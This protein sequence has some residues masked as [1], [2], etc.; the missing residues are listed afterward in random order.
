MDSAGAVR[1][2]AND[3]R[4]ATAHNRHNAHAPTCLLRIETFR[5]RL[6]ANFR[7]TSAVNNRWVRTDR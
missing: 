4:H 6:R 5:G 2:A 3:V 7:P 1:V